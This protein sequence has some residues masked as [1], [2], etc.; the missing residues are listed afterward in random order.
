MYMKKYISPLFAIV[1][2][3]L[4][5]IAGAAYA[6]PKISSPEPIYDFGELSNTEVVPHDFVIKNS[7]DAPLIISDVKTSC[8]CTVATMDKKTLNP[9]EE[10]V[11]SATLK[12][13]GE[14]PRTKDISVMSNDPDSPTYILK[15]T[16]SAV[17]A[18]KYEPNTLDFGQVLDDEPKELKLKIFS[19]LDGLT[20]NITDLSLN[21]DFLEA[22][23]ET[24]E[25]GKSYEITVKNAG[26]FP[27]GR[28]TAMLTITTDNEKAKEFRVYVTGNVL[29]DYWIQPDILRLRYDATPGK[30]MDG[31][32]RV[33]PGK[34]KE[35][36]LIDS[37]KPVD[38]MEVVF[39]KQGNAYL[40][41]L[42]NMPVDDTLADKELILKTDVPGHENVVVPISV[43]KPQPQPTVVTPTPAPTP[44]PTP[45]PE[46]APVAV[47]PAN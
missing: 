36:N 43:M 27:N 2:V 8:G 5:L 24:L 34:V 13:S 11:V 44:A 7:G 35:F 20:F 19:A 16:G 38:T 32:L 25:E 21:Q 9:G 15:F 18:I 3:A 1:F 33:S 46:A 10:T 29:G 17:A 42:K 6:G 4:I 47:E 22:S 28:L 40:V 39:E 12:L 41:R 37:V 30:V 26:P 31:F 45:T 14:G 23:Y